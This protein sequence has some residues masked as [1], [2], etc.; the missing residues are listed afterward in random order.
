MSRTGTIAKSALQLAQASPH[1]SGLQLA[2]QRWRLCSA[3]RAPFSAKANDGD[4]GKSL[5]CRITN[6]VGEHVCLT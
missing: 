3:S 1:T 2:L 4:D 6:A 5:D